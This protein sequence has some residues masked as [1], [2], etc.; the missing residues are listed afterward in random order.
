MYAGPPV[1]NAPGAAADAAYSERFKRGV[2]KFLRDT[3]RAGRHLDLSLKI[4]CAGGWDIL[5]G[6]KADHKTHP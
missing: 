5:W 1:E 4:R 6:S 2:R 3:V